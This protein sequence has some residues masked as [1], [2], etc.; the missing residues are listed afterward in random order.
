MEVANHLRCERK[1]LVSE[2][3]TQEII[4]VILLH[5]ALFSP[6]YHERFINNIYFDNLELLSL[7]ENQGGTTPRK[8]VRIRW[9]SALT[10]NIREPTL[11]VKQKFG[12]VGKNVFILSLVFPWK[13]FFLS[14]KL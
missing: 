5:P 13:T 2:L 11:E 4:E 12:I 10:G 3:T 7:Y 8:K 14:L 1:F 9:Y 6:I